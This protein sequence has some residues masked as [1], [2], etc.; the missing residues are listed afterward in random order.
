MKHYIPFIFIVIIIIVVLVFSL[1]YSI[2]ADSLVKSE[3]AVLLVGSEIEATKK[4]VQRL[5]TDG[6]SNYLIIPAYS[7]ILK[8]SDSAVLAPMKQSPS[9]Q[10]SS[11]REKKTNMTIDFINIRT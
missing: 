8:A 9:I 5:I 4:E 7:R 1:H 3:A 2:Y 6:Y 10:N 11:T